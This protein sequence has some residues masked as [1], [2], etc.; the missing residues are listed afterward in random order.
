MALLAPLTHRVL[1]VAPHADDEVIGC[2]GLIQRVRAAGGE[3]FVLFMTAGDT[4]EFSS[5]GGSSREQ[6]EDE[7]RCVAAFM[8]FADYAIAFPGNRDHLRLDARPQAEIIDTI[9]CRSPLA[10]GRLQPSAVLFPSPYSYNQDHRAVA[11][12]CL[13]ALRPGSPAFKHQPPAVL[14]YEQVVDQWSMDPSHF[15]PNYFV[16]LSKMDVEQKIAALKLYASQWREPPN[17][18]SAAALSAL[19]D[20]R[21]AQSGLHHAEAFSVLRLIAG[22]VSS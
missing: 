9:E 16:E 17:G 2:G 5:S 6:R 19:A 13:T 14:M 10:I 22:A 3:A 12:A 21:G 18:R 4:K 15:V 8:G 1:I 20:M 11:L 7:I